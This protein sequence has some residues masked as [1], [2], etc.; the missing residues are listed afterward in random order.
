MTL[1]ILYQFNFNICKKS[2]FKIS[3]SVI[4]SGRIEILRVENQRDFGNNNNCY[5]DNTINTYNQ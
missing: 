3:T 2:Q 4:P 5:N 1:K